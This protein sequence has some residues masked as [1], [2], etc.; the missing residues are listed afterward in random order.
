MIAVDI[1]CKDGTEAGKISRHLLM[2]KLVACVSMWPVRSM[3]YWNGKLVDSAEVVVFAKTVEGKYKDIIKEAGKV[4]S[5]DIPAII[6]IPI[7]SNKDYEKWLK[8]EVQS[9]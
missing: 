7:K 5:Y 1:P 2:K 4:H 3:Y 6:K 9:R 8:Q